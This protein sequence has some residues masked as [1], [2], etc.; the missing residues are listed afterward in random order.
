[1]A[2]EDQS[3]KPLGHQAALVAPSLR[4]CLASMIA[5]QIK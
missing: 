1:M 5:M 4:G 3:L 2:F